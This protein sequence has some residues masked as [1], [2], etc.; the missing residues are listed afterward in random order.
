V[1][2]H[3]SLCDY[4]IVSPTEVLHQHL[5]RQCWWFLVGTVLSSGQA[6]W[7]ELH[8]FLAYYMPDY[9]EDMPLASRHQLYFMIYGAASHFSLSGRRHINAHYP[10]RWI[11]R[12]GPIAWPPRSPDLYLWGHAKSVVYS[13]AV[14]DVRVPSLRARI[15]AA[16]QT[17]RTTRGVFIVFGTQCEDERRP[18]FRQKESLWT[19]IWYVN[20]VFQLALQAYSV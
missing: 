2:G 13:T 10:G 15:V 9:L 19:F 12:G 14:D 3:K 7:T 1:G 18:V 8:R 5:G 20:R 4:P 6:Y 11:G 17:V 16:C